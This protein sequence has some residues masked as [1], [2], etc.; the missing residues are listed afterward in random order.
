VGLNALSLLG[1]ILLLGR[2]LLMK[3]LN[4]F[5]F[6]VVLGFEIRT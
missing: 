3:I 4:L 5:F 1:I 2:R 6:F